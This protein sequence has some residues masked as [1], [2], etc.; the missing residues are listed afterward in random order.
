MVSL[1]GRSAQRY[2]FLTNRSFIFYFHTS[3]SCSWPMG[4][5]KVDVF[6][7]PFSGIVGVDCGP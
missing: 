5:R 2:A 1:G 3:V 6:K 4:T 7:V